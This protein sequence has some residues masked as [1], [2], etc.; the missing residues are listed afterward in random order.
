M[1]TKKLK[2]DLHCHTHFSDGVLTVPEI[3]MRSEQM[4]LD[5]L[6]ITDHDCIDGIAPARDY[7]HSQKQA[8]F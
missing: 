4:Q 6:A 5:V 1:S 3:L 8:R 2:I 7:L